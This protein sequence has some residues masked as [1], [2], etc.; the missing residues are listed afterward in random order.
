M[1]TMPYPKGYVG[2]VKHVWLSKTCR[3][4]LDCILIERSHQSYELVMKYLEE[5]VGK[6]V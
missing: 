6:S 4:T 1:G 5:K 2:I 3:S